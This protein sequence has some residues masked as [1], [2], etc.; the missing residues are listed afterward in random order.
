MFDIFMFFMFDISIKNA[1]MFIVV[2]QT[3][4]SLIS[5]SGDFSLRLFVLF[6]P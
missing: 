2:M 3:Q 1:C 5:R 6:M 4:K